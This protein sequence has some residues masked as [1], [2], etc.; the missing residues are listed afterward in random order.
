MHHCCMT[1]RQR[2]DGEHKGLLSASHASPLTLRSPPLTN[3]TTTVV[4]WLGG[5]GFAVI[6]QLEF[7][8]CIPCLRLHVTAYTCDPRQEATA[9]IAQAQRTK[10]QKLRPLL[11][12]SG[13]ATKPRPISDS[14][15]GSFGS[16]ATRFELFLHILSLTHHPT[17]FHLIKMLARSL[18][19]SLRTAVRPAVAGPSTRAAAVR[20]YS[21]EKTE[22]S[23]KE[24]DESTAKIAELEAKIAEM[25]VSLLVRNRY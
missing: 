1:E 6:S 3:P 11:P 21:A 4:L 20:M 2:V 18:A 22:K 24:G 14:N 16:A 9:I 23:E 12:N 19:S 25:T 17:I 5:G 8:V 15:G 13:D 10:R 7:E